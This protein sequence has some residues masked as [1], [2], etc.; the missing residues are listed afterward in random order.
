MCFFKIKALRQNRDLLISTE[1]ITEQD[2]I[3]NKK[4]CCKQRFF[5]WNKCVL[6]NLITER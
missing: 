2:I 1:I 4:R 6:L 5:S 3:E